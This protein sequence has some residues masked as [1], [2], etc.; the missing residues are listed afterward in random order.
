MVLVCLFWPPIGSPALWFNLT[1]LSLLFVG[2][3]HN[4]GGLH[5]REDCSN[6]HEY[7][8]G[9]RQ[10]SGS[11]SFRTVMAYDN[12]CNCQ[13]MPYF[14]ANGFSISGQAIG[15]PTEDNARLFRTTAARAAAYV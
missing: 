9:Y 5:N 15:T 3:G 2:S 4:L 7:A 13:R 8:H 11:S 6:D 10:I 12:G 14:S 1:F